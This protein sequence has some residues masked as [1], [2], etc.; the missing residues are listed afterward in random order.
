VIGWGLV[1]R[2]WVAGL[3]SSGHH[4]LMRI[5]TSDLT[6]YRA[7]IKDTGIDPKLKFTPPPTP[8]FS[9]MGYKAR[10]RLA[11]LTNK[12]LRDAGLIKENS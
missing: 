12:V 9:I 11:G 6:I 3:H 4:F 7:V 8:Q 2:S 10:R 1:T 5:D